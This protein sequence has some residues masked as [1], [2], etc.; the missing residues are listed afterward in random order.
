MKNL[1]KAGVLT[2]IRT[3]YLRNKSQER[4]RYTSPLLQ[5][6]FLF[7]L[8]ALCSLGQFPFRIMSEIMDLTVSRIPWTGNEPVVMP[9]TTQ[10]TNTE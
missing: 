2:D 9:L 1:R 4:Y 8:D 7:Y 10:N 3:K 6:F 5:Y